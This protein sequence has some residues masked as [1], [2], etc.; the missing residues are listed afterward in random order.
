M[1][2]L[3]RNT[4]VALLGAL[5]VVACTIDVDVG[6][7]VVHGGSGGI[8]AI[9]GEPG[10]WEEVT[11]DGWD[12]SGVDDR[13]GAQ[14]VLADPAR[15]GEFFAFVCY[16][17]AYKSV[18]FG[19]TWFK[20]SADDSPLEAGRPW[21]QAIDPNPRR[22]PDTPPTL[23][24]AV[25]NGPLGMYKSTDGGVT[26]LDS[27]DAPDGY[28]GD[29]HMIDIDPDDGDHLL[30]TFHNDN[31]LVESKDGGATWTGRGAI[32]G[33]TNSGYVFFITSRIWLLV[34]RR[35]EANGTLRTADAGKTWTKVS[36][37]EHS[38]GQSQIHV[39]ENGLVLLPGEFGLARSTDYGETFRVVIPDA[40]LN[41][42]TATKKYYYT[43]NGGFQPLNLLRSPIADGT[44]WSP[45]TDDPPG[46]GVGTKRVAVS[47]NGE[48]S[49]LVSG[50][51]L[52]GLWRYIEP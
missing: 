51:W 22:D 52:A 14:D 17:G 36:D 16:G 20:I 23:Y 46:M 48:R 47:S 5:S 10:V 7:S 12:L 8:P 1:L 42:V 43:M 40:T 41:S 49:V 25:G 33:A 32:D 13:Y 27:Y 11:P 26:W 19:K 45:Y 50:N 35:T 3:V 15:P 38:G 28:G 9:P 34:S 6:G 30:M 2:F 18:D 39:G 37:L 44:S 31:R 21:G 24:A 29:P 4:L